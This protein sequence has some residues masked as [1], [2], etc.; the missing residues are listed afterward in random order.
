VDE[1]SITT[2]IPEKQRHKYE[3]RRRKVREVFDDLNQ[4]INAFLCELRALA[5]TLVFHP[6]SS[7]FIRGEKKLFH[8]ENISSTRIVTKE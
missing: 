6:W 8:L 1:C 2:P 4:E 3:P 5:V 7:V